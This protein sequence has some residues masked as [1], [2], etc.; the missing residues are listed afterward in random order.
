M[1][2]PKLVRHV[3]DKVIHRSSGVSVVVNESSATTIWL[4]LEQKLSP[5]MEVYSKIIRDS[6]R[7][8]KK[9]K[10]IS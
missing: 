3:M 5:Q 7:E 10:E 6:L 8:S 1:A 9:T 4:N 2:V